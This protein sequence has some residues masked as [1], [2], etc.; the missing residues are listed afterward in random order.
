MLFANYFGE[1]ENSY[2]QRNYVLTNKLVSASC[3]YTPF[4]RAQGFFTISAIPN[5]DKQNIEQIVDNALN[6]AINT[7]TEQNIEDEKKKILSSLVYLK[8]DPEDAASIVGSFASLGFSIDDIENHADNIR[9]IT[10]E[11]VQQ[12]AL[13]LKAQFTN[14]TGFLVPLAQNGEANE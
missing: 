11:D 12:A 7:I 10:L 6:E 1:T 2:L 13:K 3:N 5:D 4:G 14:I 9:H 8:D